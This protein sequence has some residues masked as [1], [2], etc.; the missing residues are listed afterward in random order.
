MDMLLAETVKTDVTGSR[1]GDMA[2]IEALMSPPL[3][4]SREVRIRKTQ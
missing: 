3:T 1:K 4:L 2:D